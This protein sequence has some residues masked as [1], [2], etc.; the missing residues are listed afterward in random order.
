MEVQPGR[1]GC[2]DTNDVG[3]CFTFKLLSP[4]AVHPPMTRQVMLFKPPPFNVPYLLSAITWN[5]GMADTFF[6]QLAVYSLQDENST[7]CMPE[8]K[9]W[10]RLE[11]TYAEELA[12]CHC[13]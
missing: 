2:L 1:P 5:A 8:Q 9:K 10:Q 13:P 7:D 11:E 6:G 12:A 3:S 4:E